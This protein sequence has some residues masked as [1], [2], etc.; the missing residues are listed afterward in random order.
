MDCKFL[1][2]NRPWRQ[3]KHRYAPPEIRVEEELL[4]LR[5]TEKRVRVKAG[6]GDS[7]VAG[8]RRHQVLERSPVATVMGE[9]RFSKRD[10]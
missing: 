5:T 1:V 6:R 9:F 3:H 7:E 10:R 8:C 2:F 4:Y